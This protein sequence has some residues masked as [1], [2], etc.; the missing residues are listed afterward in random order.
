MKRKKKITKVVASQDGMTTFEKELPLPHVYYP[1][2][3]GAFFAFCIDKNSTPYF[4]TCSINAIKN[5]IKLRLRFKSR[6]NSNPN[7]N[8]ILSSAN[9]PISVVERMAQEFT[10]EDSTIIDSLLFKEN[11]CH[12][13]NRQTPQLAYCHSMY[14]GVFEQNYGWYINKQSYEDGVKPVSFQILE[15]VCSDELF[16][17]LEIG[18][19]GFISRYG[20]LDETDLILLKAHDSIYQKETRKIR[21]VIENE[22]RIKFGFNKVGEAWASETLLFQI[23]SQLYP[24]KR[25]YRHHRPEFLDYLELDVYIPDLKMGFEYQGIQH[26]EPI[27]HWGG[28]AALKELKVRDAKKKKLCEEN[29]INLIYVFYYEE[30]N[31]ELIYNKIHK[32]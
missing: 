14:G 2:F 8:Y 27:E 13:C 16:E 6:R 15:D 5:Y 9:F 17:S 31:K 30:L 1:G 10:V 22:V 25:V 28:K 4:C 24:D 19:T 18:K 3:Y 23:I 26:F 7:K 29:G 32:R 12:E 20:S 21:T 11:I